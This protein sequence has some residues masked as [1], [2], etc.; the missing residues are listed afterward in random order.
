VVHQNRLLWYRHVLR[1]HNDDWV[2]KCIKMKAEGARQ[3]GRLRKNG[4]RL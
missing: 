4:K 3:R 2:K 1:K